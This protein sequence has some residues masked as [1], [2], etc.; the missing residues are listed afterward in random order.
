MEVIIRVSSCTVDNTDIQV[1]RLLRGHF[2]R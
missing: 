1:Y 2:V